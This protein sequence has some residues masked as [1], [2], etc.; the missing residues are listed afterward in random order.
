MEM[1]KQFGPVRLVISLAP[2]H[3]R[4]IGRLD[5][6]VS[7]ANSLLR[8]AQYPWPESSAERQEPLLDQRLACSGR[9]RY[10]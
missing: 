6:A 1:V 10:R 9:I 8:A 4:L 7:R 2:L 5:K 3:T